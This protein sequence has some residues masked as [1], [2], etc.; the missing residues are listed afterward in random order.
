[1][2]TIVSA[3][4]KVLVAGGYL[5][6]DPAYSGVVVSTSSRFYTVIRSQPSV[7][8]NTILVRSPQFDAAAWTYEIK[9]NGDVEPAESK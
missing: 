5:V 8:A 1:M 6:L 4:G 2:S 3:P 7:P 9:E